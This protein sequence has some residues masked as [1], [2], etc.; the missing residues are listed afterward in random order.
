MTGPSIN[1]RAALGLG[2]C[3]TLAPTFASAKGP[4]VD[5][6]QVMK[7]LRRLDLIGQGKVLRSY[8]ISLGFTPVGAKRVEGDGKTPEG[9]YVLNARVPGSDFHLS[10]RLS[11]PNTKDLRL[12]RNLGK[13]AGGDICIHGQ[14]NGVRGL[15]RG[16]WTWGCVA[17]SNEEIEELFRVVPVGTPIRIFA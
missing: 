4:M 2:L 8:R 16:D 5:S 10:M 6:V 3:M 7:S 1:R 14:P 13:P 9:G 15:M 11:Y 12:A 17:M